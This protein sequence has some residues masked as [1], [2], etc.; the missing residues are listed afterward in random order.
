MSLYALSSERKEPLYIQISDCL[1]AEISKSFKSGDCL[2]SEGELAARFGVNRH[3]LRRA[4]DELV[5]KGLVE[6]RHG[7]GV[8]VLESHLDYRLNSGTRFTET[9]SA[10]GYSTSSRIIRMQRIMPSAR[11]AERLQIEPQAP[12]LWV[13]TLR[14]VESKPLCVISHF[15]PA[16][17]FP[18]IAT[19]YSEG[20]LHQFLT[21]TYGCKLRRTESLITALLPQGDDARLLEIAAGKPVLR[22]KSVNIDERD[23]RPVEYAISRMRGDAVELSVV[24]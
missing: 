5:N 3:T 14:T 7:R 19:D 23:N 4:I 22:V 15:L 11:I 16:E 10:K 9:L 2:S 6:R 21:S 24:L 17:R 12:V 8:F 20:S 18:E 1:E 13:E